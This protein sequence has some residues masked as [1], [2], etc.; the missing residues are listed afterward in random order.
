ML[1]HDSLHGTTGGKSIEVNLGQIR[2]AFFRTVQ[3]INTLFGSEQ[4]DPFFT[5]PEFRDHVVFGSSL[6]RDHFVQSPFLIPNFSEMSHCYTGQDKTRSFI[7]N[8][9]LIQR[10]KSYVGIL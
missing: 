5:G 4:I 9:G 1:D 7:N 3:A 8:L 10:V 2:Y 6:D